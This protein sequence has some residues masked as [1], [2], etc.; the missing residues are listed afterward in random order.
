MRWLTR[1]LPFF[2]GAWI[3]ILFL[4]PAGLL[5][6][7]FW[8]G[9]A[10]VATDYWCV[11]RGFLNLLSG[12]SLYDT[13]NGVQFGGPSVTWYLGHPAFEL[14]V[15]PWYAFFSPA[16]SFSLWSLTSIAILLCIGAIYARRTHSTLA[17][18]ACMF[19]CVFGVPALCLLASGNMHTWLVLALALVIVG[20]HDMSLAPD[21]RSGRWKLAAG[22]LISLLSKPIVLFVLPM[23]LLLRPTRRLALAVIAAYAAVSAACVLVPALNPEG[24]GLQR[25]IALLLDPGYVRE[26]MNI[27]KNQFLVTAEMKDNAIHWLNLVAQSDFY[28]NHIQIFSLSAFVNDVS[29]TELPAAIYKIPLFLALLCSLAVVRIRDRTRQLMAATWTVMLLSLTF[30]LCYN[31]VWEYQFTAVIPLLLFG[32]VQLDSGSDKRVSCVI[33]VCG[34]VLAMPSFY[35]LFAGRPEQA[36]L[37]WVRLPR[38]LPVVALYCAIL[39]HLVHHFLRDILARREQRLPA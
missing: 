33:L 8:K 24:V 14:L 27:Y 6:F 36:S 38:V 31:T 5:D 12:H 32:V 35:F 16:T 7:L 26:H 25:E 34:L 13:F 18:S 29:G 39:W 23:V 11:P 37:V 17:R 10:A 19:L 1:L 30:F 21:H 2:T 28:W 20:L 15:A 4:M 22:L 9:S 3:A